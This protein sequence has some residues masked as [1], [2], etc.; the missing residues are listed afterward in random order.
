MHKP[1]LVLLASYQPEHQG[2]LASCYV[3]SVFTMY[4]YYQSSGHYTLNVYQ[5]AT[6]ST[7]ATT[8]YIKGM[9]MMYRKLHTHAFHLSL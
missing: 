1:N 8:V 9:H 7:T 6:V 2:L 5:T 3:S 4:S